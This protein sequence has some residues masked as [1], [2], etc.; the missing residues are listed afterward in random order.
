M[1]IY[2]SMNHEELS[3]LRSIVRE[4]T[5]HAQ[6]SKQALCIVLLICLIL[7]NLCMGSSQMPSII[8]IERC[9]S[10]YWYIQVGFVILC[11]IFTFIAVRIAQRNQTLRIKYNKINVAP[12]DILYN[13][14]SSLSQLLFLAFIGGLV[15][16]GLGLGGGSIYNPSL[17]HMGIPP[18]VSAASGLYLVSFSC[19]ASVMI[20]YMHDDLEVR[21]GLWI[22]FWACVCMIT[23]LYFVQG[24]IAKT[25]RQSII[26]WCLVAIFTLSVI[27][28]PIFGGLSLKWESDRGVDITAFNNL[29]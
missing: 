8:G 24:Y 6:W 22:G 16:G 28:V 26:V 4:E 17:L 18:K 14:K 19:I 21:Y 9:D 11:V 5:S 13:D 25:G 2:P 23:V 15:G 3:Q 20:H 12:T 7:M 29:C 27:A 10:T 1:K